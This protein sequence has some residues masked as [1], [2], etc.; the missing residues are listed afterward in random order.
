MLPQNRARGWEECPL[1]PP[2]SAPELLDPF[3]PGTCL[4]SLTGE[5]SASKLWLPTVAEAAVIEDESRW[6]PSRC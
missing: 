6:G 5:A 1:L 4:L 2:G 3:L